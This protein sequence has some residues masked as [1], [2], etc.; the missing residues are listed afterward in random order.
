M[1]RYKIFYDTENDRR[2]YGLLDIGFNIDKINN[3][4][5][6]HKLVSK[7]T[8]FDKNEYDQIELDWYNKEKIG[9]SWYE[10][11]RIKGLTFILTNPNKK[12]SFI[13]P[14]TKI[15]YEIE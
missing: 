7:F 8:N 9:I 5:L 3:R 13:N 6:K 12:I 14:R 10:G 1:S 2:L 4:K 15:Y 11:D